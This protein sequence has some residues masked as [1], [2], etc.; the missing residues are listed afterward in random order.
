MSLDIPP[1]GDL[2]S[3]GSLAKVYLVRDSD[4]PALTGNNFVTFIPKQD[5]LSASDAFVSDSAQH[6]SLTGCAELQ[7]DGVLE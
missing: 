5:A 6:V 4:T 2:T 3:C 1:W 7:L